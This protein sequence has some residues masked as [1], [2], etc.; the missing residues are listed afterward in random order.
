MTAAIGAKNADILTLCVITL[1]N[2]V[3]ATR[4]VIFFSSVNVVFSYGIRLTPLFDPFWIFE[5]YLLNSVLE[6]G[7]HIWSHIWQLLKDDFYL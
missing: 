4:E 5:V 2:A 7:E 6:N 1:L 3:T